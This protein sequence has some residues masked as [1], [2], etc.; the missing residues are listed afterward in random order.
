MCANDLSFD[1]LV[2]PRQLQSLRGVAER[3]PD[4]PIV[5]D[6]AGKP[7]VASGELSPWREEMNRLAA[8]QQVHCKLSGLV[9]EAAPG[10]TAGALKPYVAAILSAFGPERVM[11]GSDW[12]VLDLASSY[13]E[14]VAL[15]DALLAGLNQ[16]ER[17]RVYGLNAAAFYRL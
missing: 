1:A 10:W 11:W 16:H 15:S 6:H 17:R 12:P 7:P 9:T 14:W 8:L 13:D 3:Y 2:L 4:L 5:I